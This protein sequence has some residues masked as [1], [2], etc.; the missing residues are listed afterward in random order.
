[1]V[2]LDLDVDDVDGTVVLSSPVQQVFRTK[3]QKKNVPTRSAP[4]LKMKKAPQSVKEEKGLGGGGER[5]TLAHSVKTPLLTRDDDIRNGPRLMPSFR[6]L[7]DLSI[8]INHVEDPVGRIP[9]RREKTP[10]T[11]QRPSRVP[12]IG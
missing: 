1:M 9:S 10:R 12:F 2:V 6:G 5:R 7:L 11:C 4:A 8:S 3:A